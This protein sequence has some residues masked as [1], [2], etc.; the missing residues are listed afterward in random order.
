MDG[1]PSEI[2]GTGALWVALLISVPLGLR[3][4]GERLA[5]AAPA[6]L[7]VLALQALHFAEEFATGFQ[8]RLPARLGL[9]G[10]SDA[11]FVTF[12][13]AW[14]AIWALAL[15]GAMAGR[16][17][18]LAAI[19]LW[20]LGLA[21]IGNGVGHPI[22]A[23]VAGGYFPGLVTAPFLGLAGIVLVRRLAGVRA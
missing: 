4:P 14:I 23:V 19:P 21:A 3:T 16:M 17:T 13:A 15:A 22:L 12:N 11:F 2:L 5:T 10:W 9:D 6:A 20:F 1:V 8:S 18:R 7:V